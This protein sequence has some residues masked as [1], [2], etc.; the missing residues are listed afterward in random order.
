[1]NNQDD[2]KDQIFT[3]HKGSQNKSGNSSILDKRSFNDFECRYT[4]L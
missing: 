2:K 3:V 4:P 1:M